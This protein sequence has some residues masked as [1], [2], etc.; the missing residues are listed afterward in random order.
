VSASRI[1]I[2]GEKVIACCRAFF[3]SIGRTDRPMPQKYSIFAVMA[4]VVP[5][6][7]QVSTGRPKGLGGE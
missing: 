3:S 4:R 6:L 2:D 5:F 1:A 7:N